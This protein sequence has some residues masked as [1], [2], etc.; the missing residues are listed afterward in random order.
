VFSGPKEFFPKTVRF[1]LTYNLCIQG[2]DANSAAYAAAYAV[3]LDAQR[4]VVTNLLYFAA[5]T[6]RRVD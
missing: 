4:S 3:R 1:S 2:R 6:P 5:S